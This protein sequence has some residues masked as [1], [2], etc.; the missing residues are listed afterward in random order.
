VISESISLDSVLTR[1][2]KGVNKIFP[3]SPVVS[4]QSDYSRIVDN[5]TRILNHRTQV[6]KR[7][8][9]V[10]VVAA[11]HNVFCLPLFVVTISTSVCRP[12]YK[13]VRVSYVLSK[14][15]GYLVFTAGFTPS[16]FNNFSTA[17]TRATKRYRL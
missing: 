15:V 2:S 7:F 4:P 16:A 6:D 5:T 3:V 10:V 1:P 13:R 17:A 9:A 8:I 14:F 11:E 12:Q